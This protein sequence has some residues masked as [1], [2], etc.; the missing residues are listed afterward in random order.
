MYAS[1]GHFRNA[2]VNAHIADEV[3]PKGRMWMMMTSL[4]FHLVMHLMTKKLEMHS[5]L[6]FQWLENHATLEQHWRIMQH[7]QSSANK[8]SL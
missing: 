5:T 4:A 6:A 1:H 2:T 7:S 8:A 3:S